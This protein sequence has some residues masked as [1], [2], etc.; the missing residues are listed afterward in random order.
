MYPRLGKENRK[1]VPLGKT[2]KTNHQ[3]TLSREKKCKSP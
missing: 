2:G 3:N 1:I